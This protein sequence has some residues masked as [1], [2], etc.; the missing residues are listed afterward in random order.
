[1]RKQKRPSPKPIGRPCLPD[2]IVA[3]R[4]TEGGPA[5]PIVLARVLKVT[6]Y[7]RISQWQALDSEKPRRYMEGIQFWLADV[8]LHELRMLAAYLRETPR[9]TD[10]FEAAN[11]VRRF[12][13]QEER[14]S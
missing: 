14:T 9:F 12:V 1:M 4:P 6:R 13:I 7:G 2:T 8:P 5:G 11:W 3:V 10:N